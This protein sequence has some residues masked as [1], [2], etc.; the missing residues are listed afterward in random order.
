MR[1]LRTLATGVLLGALG[2][3]G[4]LAWERYTTDPYELARG[5]VG[6]HFQA[7]ACEDMGEPAAAA[8]H[9]RR[10]DTY[11]R[12]LFSLYS[13]TEALSAVINAMAGTPEPQCGPVRAR[14]AADATGV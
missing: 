11:R 10:A 3:L 2:M 6:H 4:L 12:D 1:T 8:Q 7:L 9:R 5:Y 13:R 14:A